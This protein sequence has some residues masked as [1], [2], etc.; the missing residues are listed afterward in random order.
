MEKNLKTETKYLRDKPREQERLQEVKMRV[1]EQEVRLREQ[2]ER[3]LEQEGLQEQEEE[4]VC[5]PP[6]EPALLPSPPGLC[7]PTCKM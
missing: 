2:E 7:F 3:L 1:W 4:L 5:C 6:G